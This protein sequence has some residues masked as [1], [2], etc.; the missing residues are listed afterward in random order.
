MN[1]RIAVVGAGIVGL[2]VAREVLLR[3]PDAVVS[4][5]EKEA[6]PAVH[7]TEHNSGVIHSGIYYPAGSEK[8]LRCREGVRL[9]G[10]FCD[11]QGIH[12]RKC[13]KLIVATERS[14]IPRLEKIL[15]QG[16][17][18]GIENV[19]LIEGAEISEIEPAITGVMAVYVPGVEI[20]DYR[21]VSSKIADD[22]RSR[23]GRF[24]FNSRVESIQQ[25]GGELN[26]RAGE[27]TASFDFLIN[28]GGLESDRVAR[29]AGES[30][31]V[32]IV[33]FRGEYYNLPDS[34]AEKIKAMIYPVP[35][36]SLPFLG[37]HL[38]PT[39][40]SKM[41]A[42]P[43]AVLALAR[44][45]YS[46]TD[47]S[48]RDIADYL[49]FS[50]FWKLA[51]RYPRIGLYEMARSLSKTIYARSV[52]KYLPELNTHDLLPGGSGVRAQAV[53]KDGA[54][55]HDFVYIRRDR[56]LHVLNAPSPAATASLAIARKVVDESF[57]T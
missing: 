3:F 30:P 23:G 29:L 22:V 21:L 47:V 33:P 57:E 36:P 41:T 50:G 15:E 11:E 17:A 35:D 32:R 52:R 43:N 56:F 20:V 28:C 19:R 54:M 45:G 49:G 1:K 24:F 10:E 53:S 40:D 6:A 51:A 44:E 9:L 2:S 37:V 4:V 5:F 8:A 7:Q 18:N 27:N 39:I 31:D 38:T 13:G 16:R 34:Y 55:M 12:R 46:W 25:S 42:G 48:P 26:V 14:E